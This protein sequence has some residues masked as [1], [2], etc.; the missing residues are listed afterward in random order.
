MSFSRRVRDE[1]LFGRGIAL[2]DDSP[3]V[4]TDGGTPETEEWQ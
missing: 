3:A 4:A 2:R 1:P